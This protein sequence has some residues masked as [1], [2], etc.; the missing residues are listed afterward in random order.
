MTDVYLFSNFLPHKCMK[1]DASLSGKSGHQIHS[2]IFREYIVQI[3][4]KFLLSYYLHKKQVVWHAHIEVE[5]LLSYYMQKRKLSDMLGPQWSK[6]E[7]EYFY[8]AYRKHGK[9]WKKVGSSS[10]LKNGLQVNS[11]NTLSHSNFLKQQYRR[12]LIEIIVFPENSL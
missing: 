8:E 6:E 7:L 1:N 11:W 4:L 10:N 2:F 9:D 3:E 12:F 5:F